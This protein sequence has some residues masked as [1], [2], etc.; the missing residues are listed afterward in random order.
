M[1]FLFATPFTPIVTPGPPPPKGPLPGCCA[2]GGHYR[3]L[4]HR[5]SLGFADGKRGRKS[6]L[7]HVAS[8]SI[9]FE[10]AFDC[11]GGGDEARSKANARVVGS[12][13]LGPVRFWFV[14]SLYP[15]A[16]LRWIGP[17]ARFPG[18]AYVDYH[19]VNYVWIGLGVG[20]IAF[21]VYSLW[22][23]SRKKPP[24][25]PLGW[26]CPHCHEENPANFNECW[27]CQ[28]IRQAG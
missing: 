5:Q 24:V 22:R 16:T 12:D 6:F 15:N 13:P 20:L 27:K 17:L 3:H 23:T 28:R 21:T 25:E 11:Q 9:R 2:S 19:G 26:T 7:S 8:P 1:K 14:P 18:Y 4:R 10:Y